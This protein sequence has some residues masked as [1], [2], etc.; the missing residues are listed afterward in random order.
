MFGLGILHGLVALGLVAGGGH[1]T[2]LT[3]Q[4]SCFQRP[5]QCGYP[6][7]TN[8]G[9]P[10]GTS[11][12]TTG[13]QTVTDDGTVLDGLEIKGTVTVAASDVTIENSRVVAPA[14]GSGSFAILLEEG[15]DDFTIKDSEVEGPASSKDGLESAVW[16]HYGNPGANTSGVYFHDCADCW[17]GS[18]TFRDSYMVVD[19][20]YS[21]SHDEDIY[22]CGG[23]V[24]VLHS[25]LI[26][27]HRQT[28]AVFGDTSGCGAN[29]LSITGSLLAGG[30]YVLYPQ[31]NSDS[32]TGTMNISENRF[33]R[34]HS[35][36]KFNRASGGTDCAGGPDPNGLFANGGYFGIAA[37]Y[38]LGGPNVWKRNIWDDNG[39]PVCPTGSCRR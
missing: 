24:H 2:A 19:A 28:A 13:S 15:A 35:A 8:T 31:A 27:R 10:A 30:G 21:G 33:A 17:E 39:R 20:A 18:G 16:N 32:P 11:L 37:Y 34:C 12:T 5:S 38:Y 23:T 36:P 29:H 22:V 6:D 9:V 25:T 7:A 3:D 14:G 4:T 1:T 26:N